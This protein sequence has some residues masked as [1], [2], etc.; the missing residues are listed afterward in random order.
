MKRIAYIF[1]L[2]LIYLICSAKGCTEDENMKE[3]REEKLIVALKDSV[4]SVFE[5]DSVSDQFM[6]AYEETARQKLIDFADY[7]KIV[8]DT[9]LD[10][11]FRQQ[12]VDMVSKL[13]ISRGINIRNWDKIYSRPGFNTFEQLLENSLSQGMTF[14]V[15][16]VQINVKTPLTRQNDSTLAGTLSFYQRRIPF[17]NQ[18]PADSINKMLV[19]DIYTLKKVKY[20]DKEELR[21]WEVFLG[22]IE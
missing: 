8:S 17:D 7:M 21:I 5:T 11:K 15:Q 2:I 20:F 1:F 12:A 18:I 9:S 16:P 19:I 13:F 22:D 6:R 4:R 14:W 10:I 3:L